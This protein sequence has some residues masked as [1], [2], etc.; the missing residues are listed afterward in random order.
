MSLHDTWMAWRCEKD[1]EASEEPGIIIIW[2]TIN[3]FR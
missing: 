1:S 2:K 3:K